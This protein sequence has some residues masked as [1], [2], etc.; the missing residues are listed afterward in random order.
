MSSLD[1]VGTTTKKLEAF[2][3]SE[4]D[5]TLSLPPKQ[6]IRAMGIWLEA[7]FAMLIRSVHHVSQQIR[8]W[9]NNLID[10]TAD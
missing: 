3:V 2:F 4:Y 1:V 6:Y 10:R 8:Q 7:R 9:R 5:Q